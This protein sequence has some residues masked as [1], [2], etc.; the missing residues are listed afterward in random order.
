M[1][2][3]SHIKDLFASFEEVVKQY[4]ICGDDIIVRSFSKFLH[5]FSKMP[6]PRKKGR[7]TYP[8]ESLVALIFLAKCTG[9]GDNCCQIESY[10]RVKSAF[11]TEIGVLQ[12]RKYP[13]H[14]TIRRFLTLISP[15][16]LRNNIIK[17]II[18]V[19]ESIHTYSNNNDK[20]YT[21]YASDG[22]EF[23]GTGRKEGT[24]NACGNFSTH[25]I[26]NVSAGIC[27]YSFPLD[28]KDSEI[29][30]AQKLFNRIN[31]KDV[32]V[33]SDALHTQKVTCE[34]IVNRKGYYVTP[35]K[36]NQKSLRREIIEAF[37][38]TYKHLKVSDEIKRENRSF[39]VI[40]VPTKHIGEDWPG[41]RL[42]IKMISY[43]RKEEGGNEM[44]FISNLK[45]EMAV[46]EA[47]ENRWEI[48]NGLHK[49]RDYYLHEDLFSVSDKN[50]VASFAVFNNAVLA[51]YK[52]VQGLLGVKERNDLR[53]MFSSDPVKY[54]SLVLEIARSKKLERL[55]NEKIN[56]RKRKA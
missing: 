37:N 16:W 50:A 56:E 26:M 24:K 51:F 46:I 38:G 9:N 45:D 28:E 35:A 2:E 40:K 31:L 13:S 19:F 4:D 36:D 20:K 27:T 49:D 1:K 43:V 5:L 53:V 8:V 17:P 3:T 41:Q 52:V 48:E 6:D 29:P 25:N 7:V 18:N 54:I 14:D 15:D 42:Y 34:I 12:D 22:Q 55:I 30:T 21:Q 10:A 11:L 23:R 44:Y 39:W 33:T 32:I 47:I